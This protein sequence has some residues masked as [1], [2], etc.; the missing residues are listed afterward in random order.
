[1]SPEQ[2]RGKA[3]D[4]RT[5][6]WAFACV[7]YEML[8]GRRAFPGDTMSDTIAAVIGRD[9]DWQSLPDTTPAA[10]RRLLRRC[11]H[12][13]SNHRLHDIAD[14][15]IELEET[16]AIDVDDR[17]SMPK[18]GE[19]ARPWWPL[20]VAWMAAGAV[21]AALVTIA[22]TGRVSPAS[23][24]QW[25]TLQTVATQLTNYGGSE[26]S[27]AIAPD[28]RTFAFV[29]DHGGTPDI[30]L[31]QVSGGD[32]VRLT[33]DAAEEADLE[34]APD[35]ES[36]FF[37]LTDATEP[38]IWRIGALGGQARK[39]LSNAR[40]PALSPDGRSLAFYRNEPSRANVLM[41]S[42]LDGSG[43]RAL[44][45]DQRP[46]GRPAWSPDGRQL[47]YLQTALLGPS[48]VFVVD[49]AT[50]QSR[51]VTRFT[52]GAEGVQSLVWLPDNRH[53]AVALVPPSGLLNNDLALLDVRDG[54]IVRLTMNVDGSFGTLRISEDGSRLIASAR[55]IRRE[56]RKV[57]FGHDPDA[58]GRA[59]VRVLDSTHDPL[60]TFVSHDGRTLLFNSPVSGRNLWTMPLDGRAAPRQ[61]TA[62]PGNAVAHS[63]LSPDG[64]RVA[65][66]SSAAGTSDIWVQNVDGTNLQQLTN[67]AAADAWPI[68][69]PEGQWIAFMAQRDGLA[70]TWRVPAD[71]GPAEKMFDD[72][73]R[74]DW[75]RQPS[76]SGTWIATSRGNGLR[77]IDV[78]RQAVLWEHRRPGAA[79]SLP[80]FSPDGRS[81]SVP[82]EESRDRDAIWTYDVATG[83]PRLAVRFP[84][85]F[86][87]FF[88]ASWVDGGEAFIVNRYEIIS[89]IVLFDRFWVRDKGH[90]KF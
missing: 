77:L 67:D 3:A 4:K 52:R 82:F 55:Q 43:P 60:W 73:L 58:N 65:F 40:L 32:P 51:Q 54:S 37:T 6:I 14:A 21:A 30:W 85:P 78:E 71:G 64:S 10:V 16:D 1:M 46:S 44:S 31:R 62:I 72:G 20:A 12:K 36:I 33:N 22:L 9:P 11:L 56:L 88:R 79:F 38:S 49:A 2:A 19:V 35:G 24:P 26:T 63:S 17:T 47:T 8:T 81:I 57:P 75:I 42:A 27:G 61:I 41:V 39:V 28:G 48:N 90:G 53:V 25:S 80:V 50:A 7:L 69:S 66:A 68:W 59:A 23:A 84:R 74:G 76:G 89:H 45:R 15:R 29:S 13:D 87:I 83:K 86:K 34:Y 70:E 5:D 18:I